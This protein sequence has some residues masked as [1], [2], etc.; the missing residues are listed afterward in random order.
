MVLITSLCVVE[1]YLFFMNFNQEA[2]DIVLDDLEVEKCA[3]AQNKSF[4]ICI[5]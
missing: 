3:H 2:A 1:L 4:P 5:I